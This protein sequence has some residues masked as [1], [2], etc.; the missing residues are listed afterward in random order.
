MMGCGGEKVLLLPGMAQAMVT[1]PQ[2]LSSADVA[3]VALTV[4]GSGMTQRTDELVKTGAQWGGVLGKI[5][6]GSDRT[7]HGE[8]FDTGGTL[9]YMGEV[10]GVSITAGQTTMVTL[11][12]QQVAVPT[13]FENAVPFITSVVASTSTVGL[14]DTVTLQASALD[15]DA[16]DS[17]TYAWTASA[18][19]FSAPGS[20]STSWTAPSVP[21]AVV[22]LLTVTDSKGATATVSLNLTVDGALGSA[23]VNVTFNR[24]PQVTGMTAA[25]TSVDVGQTTTVTAVATDVDG[26]S[27]G[28]QWTSTCQGTWANATS[29]SASFTPTA[30]PPLANGCG[31]CSLKVSVAD[32]MGGETTGTLGICV[33]PV[34]TARFPPEVV[35]T[36]QSL[37]TMPASGGTVVFRVK[38]R[39]PQ[40]SAL[41][42][43]W[44][45][46]AGTLGTT[47]DT[48]T[49]SELIW[50]APACIPLTTALLVKVSVTNALG[51]STEASLT[52]SGGTPCADTTKP[53]IRLASGWYHTAAWTQAAG[54]WA[55]GDNAFGQLGDGTN[56]LRTPPVQ[57]QALTG[58]K[59]VSSGAYHTVALKQD[60]TLWAWGFNVYGQLGNGTTLSRSAPVQVL[61]IQ[62][63]TAVA[64]GGHHTLVLR[65]DGTVW[66]WGYNGYGQLGDG[67][68]NERS[69]AAPV[70]GLTDV[71]AIAAGSNHSLALRQDGTVW[72]WG[73]NDFGQLGDGTTSHRRSPVQVPGL[74]DVTAL[75]AGLFHTLALKQDT[76]VWAWGSNSHGQLGDGTVAHRLAPVQ[77]DGLTGVT[78]L[79]GGFAHTLALKQDGTAW[80]WGNNSHGQLGDGTQTGRSTPAQVP[81]LTGVVALSTGIEH[82]LASKRDGTAW[83]WGDNSHGQLGDGTTVHRTAPT[84][85][86]GLEN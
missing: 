34:T 39:D 25:P 66:S 38:A 68:D 15:T 21:G 12:L 72:A 78:S 26:D 1:F 86:Q 52:L 60:G 20:L 81:G 83:A 59:A 53:V 42:Y 33:G 4:S 32:G 67:T 28:Y 27:L 74:T 55:W 35:E 85:V 30:L 69:R 7:F 18:G 23:D 77:V 24:G 47:T 10:K 50:T 76:T 61:D 49:T 41:S 44:T 57:L 19:S 8:A 13:P 71:I 46:N 54:A 11:V 80:A 45:A 65:Q 58:M 14:G 64:A 17:L 2:S 82:S 51:L 63:A 36:F 6:E 31:R 22:L 62:D 5:P 37:A 16:T 73:Y 43:S 48:A 79:A 84:Q 3:R 56:D 75:A 70:T 9:L 40:G 29:S